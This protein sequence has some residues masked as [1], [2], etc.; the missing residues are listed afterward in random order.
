MGILTHL[1]IYI[2]YIILYNYIIDII[3][4]YNIIYNII[5][6]Y[7]SDLLCTL[8]AKIKL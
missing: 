6:I 3:S 8:V 4:L 1:N 2:Y 7:V 5:Y